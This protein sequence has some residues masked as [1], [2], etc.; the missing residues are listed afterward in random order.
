MASETFTFSP[1][2]F[3]TLIVTLI[4]ITGGAVFWMTYKLRGVEKDV[5]NMQKDLDKNPYLKAFKQ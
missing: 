2:Q 1:D 4:S 3:I 5:E